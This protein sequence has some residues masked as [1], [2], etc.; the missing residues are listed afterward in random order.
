LKWI[1]VRHGEILSNIKRVYSGRSDE[2][3]TPLGVKQSHEVGKALRTYGINAVY[4]SPLK[5]TDRTA[6]IICSYFNCNP[7]L[8]EDLIELG[9]GP[10][11]GMSEEAVAAKYP[12]EWRVWHTRPAELSIPKRE[13]L[14]ELQLRILNGLKRIRSRHGSNDIILVVTHVAIIRVITLYVEGRD[15]NEYRSISV[16]NG[17]IFVFD[18]LLLEFTQ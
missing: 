17:S 8:N 5:R 2:D 12:D 14:A 15:L 7:A 1:F 4:C 10:W 16:Q 6:E 3:L 18:K 11:E 13:T 9:M